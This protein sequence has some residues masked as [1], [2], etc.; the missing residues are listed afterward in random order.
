MPSGFQILLTKT[1]KPLYSLI[2]NFLI[3]KHE[4]KV[5]QVEEKYS[6][7]RSFNS[8]L[9]LISGHALRCQQQKKT[10]MKSFLQSI[11][12]YLYAFWLYQ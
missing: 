5:R 4:A 9:S 12:V 1:Y 10:H 6:R 11:S 2:F 3:Q 8:Q 7:T